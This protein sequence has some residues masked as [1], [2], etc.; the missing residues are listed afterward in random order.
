MIYDWSKHAGVT[1]GNGYGEG[2]LYLDGP[3]DSAHMVEW[4]A[5]QGCPCKTCGG[6]IHGRRYGDM[7]TIECKKCGAEQGDIFTPATFP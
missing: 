5:P 7:T 2:T 3:Q 4:A 6:L 1:V